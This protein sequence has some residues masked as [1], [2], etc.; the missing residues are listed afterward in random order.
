MLKNINCQYPLPEGRKRKTQT[1]ESAASR[2][3]ASAARSRRVN[4]AIPH[5]LQ[6]VFSVNLGD[7]AQPLPPL[8][9]STGTPLN[10]PPADSPCGGGGTEGPQLD[11]HSL[12]NGAPDHSIESPRNN[13]G[14][15]SCPGLSQDSS[16]SSLDGTTSRMAYPSNV[17]T[18]QACSPV[19]L[20]PKA[21]KS[22]SPRKQDLAIGASPVA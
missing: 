20:M 17:Y 22:W 2:Q 11:N 12:A 6:G 19:R 10:P 14:S 8:P 9:K 3:A 5:E 1:E 15:S 13:S 7:V 16:L 18:P 4:D 21:P